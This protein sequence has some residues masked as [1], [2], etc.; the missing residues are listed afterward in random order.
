MR[1]EW[2]RYGSYISRESC[3]GFGGAWLLQNDA[4][5]YKN[6]PTHY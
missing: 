4:A 1:E 6:Q 5:R 2:T 3:L